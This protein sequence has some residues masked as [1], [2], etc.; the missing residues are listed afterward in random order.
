MAPKGSLHFFL[1]KFRNNISAEM[2]RIPLQLT[3]IEFC[4]MH[5]LSGMSII[6]RLLFIKTRLFLGNE[7]L[8]HEHL[9]RTSRVLTLIWFEVRKEV[10]L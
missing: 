2:T 3:N 1:L 9:S 8:G 4:K 7:Q 10:Q 6:L 5:Y